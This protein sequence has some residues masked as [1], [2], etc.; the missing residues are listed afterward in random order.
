VAA[1]GSVAISPRLVPVTKYHVTSIIKPMPSAFRLPKP[2]VL[3]ESMRKAYLQLPADAVVAQRIRA[4]ALAVLEEAR[5]T[6]AS[7]PQRVVDAF[8]SHLA[9]NYHYSL[10]PKPV[11]GNGDPTAD[12]LFTQKE[13]YC[14][15]FA[16][17]FVLLCRSV[18][19]P[20]R[21]VTGFANGTEQ[22]LRSTN[23]DILLVV[24][25]EDAHAWAEVFLPHY[26]WYTVDPTAGSIPVPTTWQRS[27][28]FFAD[29][30][31]AV[32]GF[33]LAT[34]NLVREDARLRAYINL[35][36][37]FILVSAAGLIYWRRERPPRMPKRALSDPQAR[38][39]VLA[40][41]ARMLRWLRLWG[42]SKPDGMTASVF[43]D[44]LHALNP[45]I[46]APAGG[47]ADLYVLAHYGETPI[48]DDDA[49]RAVELLH[50]LW[51]VG[52]RERRHLHARDTEAQ[53]A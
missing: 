9:R 53:D 34:V 50:E 44:R 39:F 32:R 52:R 40:A 1:D 21:F 16:S 33:F 37:A 45:E 13:G 10:T 17:A 31:E 3:E 36:V 11:A 14:V 38:D 8:Q 25:N 18:D 27:W 24:T 19:I 43:Q 28:N 46:A 4:M 23:G 35:A 5:L 30:F 42:V 20:A 41:Y 2:I 51:R 7:E 47:I 12:F 49:R 29:T 15:Y 6:P 22:G 48:C 26:G